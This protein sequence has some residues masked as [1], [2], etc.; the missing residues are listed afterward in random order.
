MPHTPEE[1]MPHTPKPPGAPEKMNPLRDLDDIYK[2]DIEKIR[3]ILSNKDDNTDKCITLIKLIF[4]TD[5]NKNASMLKLCMFL[6]DLQ[7]DFYNKRQET[8][9]NIVL[10]NYIEY[11]NK[12]LKAPDF[13]SYIHYFGDI[14]DL[15]NENIKIKKKPDSHTDS[16]DNI[17]ISSKLI[18]NMREIVI[19][20]LNKEIKNRVILFDRGTIF[21]LGN[22][23]YY[24]STD[25]LFK[26]EEKYLSECLVIENNVDLTVK[27][28]INSFNVKK[29]YKHLLQFWLDYYFFELINAIILEPEHKLNKNLHIYIADFI[30][31]I[32]FSIEIEDK[33]IFYIFYDKKEIVN[34]DITN[35]GQKS[36]VSKF[37][38]TPEISEIKKKALYSIVE[39]MIKKIPEEEIKIEKNMIKGKILSVFDI[40]F[41][42]LKTFGDKS[43]LYITVIFIIINNINDMNINFSIGTQDI[44]FMNSYLIELATLQKNLINNDINFN[45]SLII[46]TNQEGINRIIKER[47]IIDDEKIN[48]DDEKINEDGLCELKHIK[49]LM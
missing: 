47:K 3:N 46:K 41:L 32:N 20:S 30:K 27:D 17:S 49:Y 8:K 44:Q 35:F 39:T 16:I 22:P 2:I 28:I 19:K 37:V 24:L 11:I 6:A 14:K 9:E 12:K 15:E 34:I 7:H 43:F 40:L 48:E 26:V 13:I 45:L 33:W 10:K 23:N 31:N 5:I 21:N 38:T 4:F 42:S 18:Y 25:G 36:K 1:K 29:I